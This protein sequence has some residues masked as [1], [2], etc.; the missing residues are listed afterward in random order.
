[1][2]VRR[3]GGGSGPSDLIQLGVLRNKSPKRIGEESGAGPKNTPKMRQE[4]GRAKNAPKLRHGGRGAQVRRKAVREGAAMAPQ[5]PQKEP[6][7]DPQEPQKGRQVQNVDQK[8]VQ[9]FRPNTVQ[10]SVRQVQSVQ[11]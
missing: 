3:V 4:T 8:S 10:K 1:M 7:K 9:H 6:Q 2:R 5:R 11:T